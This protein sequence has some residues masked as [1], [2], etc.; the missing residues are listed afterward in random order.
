MKGDELL[1]KI[2]EQFPDTLKILLTGQADKKDLIK[3][4]NNAQLYRYIEKPWDIL[5]LGLTVKEALN[6]YQKTKQIKQ[7]RIQLLELNKNLE[8]RVKERTH[9]LQQKNDEILASIRYAQRIQKSIMPNFEEIKSLFKD[10]FLFYRPLGILSGDFFWYGHV[11]GKIILAA[12]DCTGHGIPG[13]IMSVIGN[14]LLNQIIYLNNITTPDKILSDLNDGVNKILHQEYSGIEDGMDLA[15]C[16]IDM[17]EGL[18]EFS[19]AKNP[20]VYIENGDLRVC[21]GERWAIGGLAEME[22]KWTTNKIS[23]ENVSHVYL[24]SDGYQDQFGGNDNKKYTSGRFKQLLFDTQGVSMED[25]KKKL[26]EAF[27]SWKQSEEQI[28]DI[29]VMGMEL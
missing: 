11:Q 21:K 12:V 8:E 23:L 22:K 3:V 24:F 9:E 15:L 20:L 25:Q 17:K 4:I 19:G 2:H 1:A 13:A 27:D 5:D 10:G 28:D 29:L 18:L 7:Q 26:E 6:L 14:N 16:S